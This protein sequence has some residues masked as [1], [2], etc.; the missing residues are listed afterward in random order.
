MSLRTATQDEARRC[1]CDV[2][3]SPRDSGR[4]RKDALEVCVQTGQLPGVFAGGRIILE[5]Q[6]APLN[7]LTIQR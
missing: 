5:L 4:A 7:L 3:L 1:V 2:I 6:I